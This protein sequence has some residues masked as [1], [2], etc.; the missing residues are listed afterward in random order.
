[1]KR[2]EQLENELDD[3]Y[4][5]QEKILD[6]IQWIVEMI[7]AESV[8]SRI[9]T[10]DYPSFESFVGNS[11]LETI[12]GRAGYIMTVTQN[13]IDETVFMQQLS[14]GKQIWSYLNGETIT[15]TEF[16]VLDTELDT[17]KKQCEKIKEY[18]NELVAIQEKID[19]VVAELATFG[20]K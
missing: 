10:A 2:A 19:N 11:K 15:K 16:L 20:D 17:Q 7:P 8:P 3:L 14:G 1:M 12:D 9:V 13:N 6:G 18:S 4:Q 5:E